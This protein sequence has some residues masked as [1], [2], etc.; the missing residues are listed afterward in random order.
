MTQKAGIAVIPPSGPDIAVKVL[1]Q[2]YSFMINQN[3]NLLYL[4]SV[5]RPFRVVH[6]AKASHY[7]VKGKVVRVAIL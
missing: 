4:A 3:F 2:P 1:R 7:K 6:E 5:V